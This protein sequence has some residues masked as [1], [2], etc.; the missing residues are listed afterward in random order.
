MEKQKVNMGRV[1][2]LA[3]AFIALLIGSGFA[4]GQE[5]MQFF[6]AWGL[7]GL[8]GIIVIC[9]LFT[10]VGLYFVEDGYYREYDRPNDIYKAILGNAF[11]TFFDYFAVFFIFLSY[12]IM[13]AGAD[14]TAMQHY[15]APKLVGGLILAAVVII[16]AMLGLSKIVDVIG[17]IGPVIAIMTIIIGLISI[18]QNWDNLSNA[19]NLVSQYR[20]GGDMKVVGANFLFA[21]FAYVGFNLIWLV[22]FLTDIG[23]TTKNLYETKSGVKLGALVFSIAMAVVSL[24][25]IL[26]IEEVHTSQIPV[27][28]LAGNVHPVLATVFSV[29]IFL[30]IF[31]S[32]VPLLWTVVDRFFTEGTK[33]YKLGALGLG[34]AGAIVGLTIGFSDLVNKAY[35][36]CGYVGFILLFVMLFRKLSG[37]Q[38]EVNKVAAKDH[39]KPYL[40]K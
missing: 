24:A 18:V 29:L 17:N 39:N 15:N 13:V 28:V 12:A 21:A 22:A 20:Q 34:V 36:Y 25:I 30:G 14:A 38:A 1:I 37:K 35:Q 8:A 9:V 19:L 27:L 10:F 40:G 11:G 16:I 23:K 33:T 4:T 7:L 32:A 31:T 5:I 3:G 26:S 2:T 6:S